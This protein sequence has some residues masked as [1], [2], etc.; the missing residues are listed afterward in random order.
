MCV[1]V[2]VCGC[3]CGCRKDI[4]VILNF[5][6]AG[7]KFLRFLVQ[8]WFYVVKCDF[9][10]VEVLHVDSWCTFL[11]N[12]WFKCRDFCFISRRQVDANIFKEM[13]LLQ[14]IQSIQQAFRNICNFIFIKRNCLQLFVVL[15]KIKSQSSQLI[16]VNWQTLQFC[17]WLQV[18]L[19]D[20]FQLWILN[21]DSFEFGEEI[22][23]SAWKKFTMLVGNSE[24]SDFVV[25]VWVGVLT[26][27]LCNQRFGCEIHGLDFTHVWTMDSKIPAIG[28]EVT[29][30]SCRVGWWEVDEDN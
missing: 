26:F 4:F 17:K 3:C 30:Q 14:L 15:E 27:D 16:T 9:E 21:C 24:G 12:F 28:A 23:N 7:L 10:F 6:F 25:C 18:V 8:S 11:K 29:L 22:F 20:D 19:S 5:S 1:C 13:D 2:F